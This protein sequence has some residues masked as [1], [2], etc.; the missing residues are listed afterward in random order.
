MLTKNN[1]KI[2]T[3]R[4]LRFYLAWFWEPIGQYLPRRMQII[5]DKRFYN[6]V[7]HCL[8]I[9]IPVLIKHYKS[10]LREDVKIFIRKD[11]Q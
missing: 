1:Q 3:Y 4:P 5:T 11:M 9:P 7:W 8:R 2:Q 6:L 10:T